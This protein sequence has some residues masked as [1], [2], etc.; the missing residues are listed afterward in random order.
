MAVS[1]QDSKVI[2]YNHL[3]VVIATA[4]LFAHTT[5]GCCVQTVLNKCVLLLALYSTLRCNESRQTSLYSNMDVASLLNTIT[6][7]T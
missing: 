1:S 7:L 3:Q 6:L 4:L 2:V 5:L